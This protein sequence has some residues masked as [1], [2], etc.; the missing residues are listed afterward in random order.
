MK[1]HRDITTDYAEQDMFNLFL[2]MGIKAMVRCESARG[3]FRHAG[4]LVT[5]ANDDIAY[6]TLIEDDVINSDDK[7]KV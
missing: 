1:K 3:Y 4:W 5:K 6:S 7:V 2:V